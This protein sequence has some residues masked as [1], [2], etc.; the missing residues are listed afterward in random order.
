MSR[1]GKT[2]LAIPAGVKITI[3]GNLLTVEGPKGKMNQ[4]VHEL[5]NV[6]QVEQTIV[7]TRPD[8]Q[9][10]SRAIHGTC[11]ANARNMVVGVTEGYTINLEL[12]GVGYRAELKGKDLNLILGFSHPIFYPVPDGITFKLDGPT[13]I[14]ISGSDKQAVGQVAAEIRKYRKPEPYKGKGVLYAGEQ[15]RRKQ[16]KKTGK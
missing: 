1:V 9:P 14:Q 3:E 11:K 2:P 10:F 16:G 13:K 6:E 5:I 8:D 7:F 4:E 12:V 15:V